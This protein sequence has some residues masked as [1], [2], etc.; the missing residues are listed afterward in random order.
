MEFKHNRYYQLKVDTQDSIIGTDGNGRKWVVDQEYNHVIIEPPIT[1]QFEIEQPN[2]ADIPKATFRIFNLSTNTRNSMFRDPFAMSDFRSVQFSAGYRQGDETLMGMLFDGDVK[3]CLSYRKGTD[4]ITELDCN[5]GIMGM[6]NGNIADSYPAGTTQKDMLEKLLSAIPGLEKPVVGETFGDKIKRAVSVFGNAA[7]IIKDLVSSDF[8]IS[9][10]G[11]PMVLALN[12]VVRG[13]IQVINSASGLIGMP[14]RSK[15][16]IEFD[17]M[18]EPRLKIKQL[19]RLES[20]N[21]DQAVGAGVAYS[22]QKPFDGEFQ[23]TGISHKG[24]I[25]G[26]VCEDLVTTVTVLYMPEFSMVAT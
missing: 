1:I 20:A 25:S 15:N 9:S 16:I 22:M 18:F 8:T 6:A 2:L 21:I 7:Q 26:A 19:I 24:T 12:E 3:S 4:W 11:V 5:V 10:Q 23:V 14:R 17:M 13:D